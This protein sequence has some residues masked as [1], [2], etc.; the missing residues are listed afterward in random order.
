MVAVLYI[1]SHR[2]G[3]GRTALCTALARTL[4]QR[5]KK[6]A[7]IKP[8]S[9]AEGQGSTQDAD[10]LFFGQILGKQAS[11]QDSSPVALSSEQLQGSLTEAQKDLTTQ[12]R[13]SLKQISAE[14]DVVVV[15]GLPTSDSQGNLMPVSGELAT[16]LD[17]QVLG[18]IGSNPGTSVQDGLS[19]K[20]VF[21]DRLMGV[22]P[23]QVTRYKEH[24]VRTQLLP[25]M[26]SQGLRVLGILPEDRRLLA[27]TVRQVVDHLGGQFLLGDEK[28]QA[29]VEHFLIGGLVLEWGVN[30]FD[31]FDN[32]AVIVRGNRPDIQ[33]AA[34]GT[35][36]A[37]L[38]LT[39]GF[40]P[41]QYVHH[42]AQEEEVPL[43]VVQQDTRQT[44]ADLE[45]LATKITFHHTAKVE[46]FQ[47]LLTK[48]VDQEALLASVGG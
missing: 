16:L 45:A 19:L 14:T 42:E 47:E 33:M 34:L 1:T 22:V 28:S 12:L 44:A 21:G 23:N 32:N 26:E 39:G 10:T 27:P 38:I 24:Q 31:H 11:L 4:V 41:I 20:E 13:R 8:L 9:L 17:A 48:G 2:P 35:P 30:Y 3:A 6:V 40:E 25:T 37:C 46:R 43:V 7:L 15:E 29:L 18:I 36:T 5:G